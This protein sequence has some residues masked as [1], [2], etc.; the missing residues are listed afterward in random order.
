[1][2]P[3]TRLYAT[4]ALA[5]AATAAAVSNLQASSSVTP[6]SNATFTWSS[7]SSDTGPWTLAVFS[8]GD[9]QTF[10]GGLA[11]A[12]NV[13]PQSNQITVLFPQVV[14]PGSY[15]VSFLSATNTS[16]VV[17]SSSSFNVGA[18]AASSPAGTSAGSTTS[19]RSGTSSSTATAPPAS[20]SASLSS[21]ASSISNAA[22]SAVSSARSVASSALSS[23]A[24]AQSQSS[25]S[26]SA[27]A[28]GP[29]NS[30]TGGGARIDAHVDFRSGPRARDGARRCGR[31]CRRS[32][33]GRAKISLPY[34]SLFCG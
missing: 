4:A 29:S 2:S 18:A 21:V 23:V 30:T 15:I 13:N 25:G 3:Y 34:A 26:G 8:S 32:I 10:P 6:D 11:I 14:S 12:N 24:S 33:I 5:F 16:D 17:A 20:I 7:D 27:S 28:S 19:A 22:S 9:N 31:G 1:M